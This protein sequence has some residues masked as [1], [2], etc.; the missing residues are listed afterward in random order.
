MS[1]HSEIC[2]YQRER[3]YGKDIAILFFRSA[4]NKV[5]EMIAVIVSFREINNEVVEKNVN[6]ETGRYC[7]C[8]HGQGDEQNGGY[9]CC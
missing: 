6:S 2:N 3:T 8:F 9:R 1:E 7:L 5:W 4:K